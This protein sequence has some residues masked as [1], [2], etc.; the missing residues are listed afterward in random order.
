MRF[1]D[2]LV[3]RRRPEGISPNQPPARLMGGYRGEAWM[4]YSA[5]G[6]TSNVIGVSPSSTSL[7]VLSLV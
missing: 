3:A 2:S 4:R 5:S 7:P 6:A 1:D